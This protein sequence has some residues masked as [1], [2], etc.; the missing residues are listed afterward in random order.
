[1][2]NFL[3]KAQNNNMDVVAEINVCAGGRKFFMDM[4][5]AK[6]ET[7]IINTFCGCDVFIS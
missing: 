4:S 3:E 5:T 7:K 1:M 2:V 6:G